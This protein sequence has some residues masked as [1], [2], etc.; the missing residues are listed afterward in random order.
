MTTQIHVL[1]E[2]LYFVHDVRHVICYRSFKN[3]TFTVQSLLM[4]LN[5]RPPTIL[6]EKCEN[7]FCT[8]PYNCWKYENDVLGNGGEMNL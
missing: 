2:R 5:N 3:V 1:G 8:G 6:Q 4:S 7:L